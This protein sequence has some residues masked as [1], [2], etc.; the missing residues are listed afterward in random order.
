MLTK[1]L[2]GSDILNYNP[3]IKVI[4]DPYGS[5]PV[6]IVPAAQPD[7][8]FVHVQRA[9]KDGNAQIWG[10]QMN[11]DLVARASQNVILTCEEIIPTREI[12]KN[13]NMTTIPSYCV[14]A[15]VLVPFGSH[16]VTTAGY[17]WMDQPF[18][19]EMVNASKTRS[20]IEAWMEEW[21]FGVRDFDAYKEKVGRERLAKLQEM[22]QDN[23]RIPEIKE[24]VR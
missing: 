13:P 12:R 19:G 22:E 11:D 23:Y 1:S 4:D 7:V 20:G 9:D 2:L 18:R 8:A 3:R 14:S 24:G 5:G 6:A 21:I 17:Y 15:V 10:M 16:P